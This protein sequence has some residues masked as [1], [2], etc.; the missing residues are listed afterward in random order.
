MKKGLGEKRIA[1]T[2]DDGLDLRGRGIPSWGHCRKKKRSTLAPEGGFGGGGVV[3]R[4][5]TRTILTW[6]LPYREEVSHLG[7][8]S[9]T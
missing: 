4:E 9:G 8:T 2:P 3:R 7:K 6:E 1:M 5:G